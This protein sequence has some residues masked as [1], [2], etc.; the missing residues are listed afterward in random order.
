[1]SFS[2]LFQEKVFAFHEKGEYL[3]AQPSTLE[4]VAMNYKNKKRKI[5][6]NQ[7]IKKIKKIKTIKKIKKNQNKLGLSCAKLSTAK[8]SYKSAWI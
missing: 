1:M 3:N 7:K 4:N 5:E 2:I 8:A 6:K